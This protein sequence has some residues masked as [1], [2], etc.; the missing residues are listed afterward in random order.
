MRPTGWG[1]LALVLAAGCAAPQAVPP[2]APAPPPPSAP[3]WAPPPRA[4]APPRSA[5]DL[6]QPSGEPLVL[7]AVVPLTGPNADFGQSVV[8]GTRLAIQ[9]ANFRFPRGVRGRLLRLEVADSAGESGRALEALDLLL[10]RHRPVA[11]IGEVLSSRTLA[12][13]PLADEVGVP[14][15]T[16]T[17][18]NPLVTASAGGRV[19]PFVF[20]ASFAD[21]VQ[22]ALMARFASERGLRRVAVLRDRGNP[23]S[24]GLAA[25]FAARLAELGG[26]VAVTGDYRS[27]DTDFRALLEAVR[28]ARVDAVYLPA[29]YTDAAAIARQARKL[30]L[31]QPFLGGDGWESPQLLERA[32]GALEGSFFTAHFSPDDPGEEVHAFVHRYRDRWR[33]VP[34]VLAALAYDAARLVIDALERAEAPGGDALRSALE[35]TR[36]FPSLTGPL[37]ID[38][39]H[40]TARPGVLMQV[41]GNDFGFVRA[42]EP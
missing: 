40:E 20:R 34:D 27:G 7:G 13:A 18:T 31:R 39:R 11:V 30:G 5:G 8:E 2:P 22:G 35:E 36:G 4:P 41:K 14:L 1:T 10:E 19:R 26:T 29:Y 6:F 23:Y 9:E 24:E 33:R 38:S 37:S 25:R 21:P 28:G 32:E 16:P 15:V 17:G 3:P 42:I 12:M